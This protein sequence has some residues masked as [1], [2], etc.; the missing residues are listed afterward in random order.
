[1]AP[2]PTAPNPPHPDAPL[3]EAVGLRKSFGDVPAVQGISLTVRPGEAYGLV[4]PDGA[5]KTT[6]MRLLVG[7]L[8]LDGGWARIGGHDIAA[9]TERARLHL[10]YLAQRFGLYGDLTVAENV[11]FFGR[12]RGV[13]GPELSARAAELLAFVGLTGFEDRLAALLSGGMKQKL[14]LAC[15]LIHRPTVVLLDEP[16]GGLDPITRQDFWQLIIRLI[17][18]GAAVIVSTPYMDEAVRCTR[19]GFLRDG[20]LLTEG[21]PSALTAPYSERILEVVAAPR[22]TVLAVVRGDPDV[23]DVT[24]FGDHFHVRVRAA[25]GP[26]GRLPAALVAAG[27]TV[28]G[29]RPIPATLEDAF[30]AL[31]AAEP[32]R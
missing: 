29:I 13:A 28:T 22:T 4:G 12:I 6:T 2:P 20:S 8:G 10:G 5:G 23:E 16:T 25:A 27:A 21:A 1:M 30:I 32:A 18:E 3:V 11:R 9:D 26:L 24:A 14:G 7:A 31:L 19:L 17:G 15:A